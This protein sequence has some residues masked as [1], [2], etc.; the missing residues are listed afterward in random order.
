MLELHR[1]TD[2]D[3]RPL[4]PMMK[5]EMLTF[6]KDTE[7]WGAFQDGDLVGVAGAVT[8]GKKATAKNDWVHPDHRGKGIFDELFRYRAKVL[9]LRGIGELEA[10][11]TPAAKASWLR[12]GATE[13]AV[14]K[15][16][17]TVM[18]INLRELVYVR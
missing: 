12:F 7:W 13:S 14:F 2:E 11:V 5:K 4:I 1:I 3:V 6:A 10:H 16:G 8:H 15:N 9:V 18:S 17:V